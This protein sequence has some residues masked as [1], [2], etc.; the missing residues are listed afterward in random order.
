MLDVS[1]PLVPVTGISQGRIFAAQ[2]SISK[3]RELPGDVAYIYAIEIVARDA[4]RDGLRAI[5]RSHVQRYLEAG[6]E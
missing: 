2:N 3:F 4:E 1:W 5:E 6:F